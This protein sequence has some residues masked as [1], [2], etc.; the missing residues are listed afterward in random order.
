MTTQEQFENLYQLLVWLQ[1]NMDKKPIIGFLDLSGP[2]LNVELA[3][4]GSVRFDTVHIDATGG[5]LCKNDIHSALL[6]FGE[7][8][9]AVPRNS[10]HQSLK[11]ICQ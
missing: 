4:R 8:W 1:K 11:G 7:M 5:P 2:G 6:P 10:D 3:D 9:W